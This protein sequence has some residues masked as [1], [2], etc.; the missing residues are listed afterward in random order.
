MS[1]FGR[2]ASPRRNGNHGS[3]R[4]HLRRRTRFAPVLDGLE[5]RALLSTFTVTN[6]NDSGSGSLRQAILDAPSGSTISFAN[7]LKGQTISL[8]SGELLIDQNLDINGPGATALAISG[9]GSSQV[10][11]IFPGANVTI[12]GLTVTDGLSDEGFGGGILTEGNL[13]L[14]NSVVT[15]NQSNATISNSLVTANSAVG[16]AG[17]NATSGSGGQGGSGEGGGVYT[18]TGAVTL[19][20]TQIAGNKAIGGPGG[21]GAAG[22]MGGTAGSA[23]EQPVRTPVRR[24]PRPDRRPGSGQPRRRRFRRARHTQRRRRPGHRRRALPGRRRHRDS[25]RHSR[26]LELRLDE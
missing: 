14:D 20:N 13:T 9:G 19:S 25:E 10:F 12:A 6:T 8:T 3:Q 5:V 24:N 26:N 16:A 2:M 1:L 17:G 11:G 18:R 4:A 23:I 22:A 15:S 7:S 21:S